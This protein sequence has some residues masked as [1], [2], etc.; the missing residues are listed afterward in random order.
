MQPVQVHLLPHGDVTQRQDLR[1]DHRAQSG[2]MW[3]SKVSANSP[4]TLPPTQLWVWLR[5]VNKPSL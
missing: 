4:D 2:S 1:G 3:G 5:K